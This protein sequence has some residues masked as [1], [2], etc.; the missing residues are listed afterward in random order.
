[1]I[2]VLGV[3]FVV[4]FLLVVFEVLFKNVVDGV[5]V[6]WEG[7]LVIWFVEF[8]KYYLDVLEGLFCILNMIFLFGMNEVKY[9]SL[10]VDLKKVI[11]NNSGLVIFVWV[12]EVGFD[13]VVV[14]YK[15]VVK[16]V[17][18]MLVNLSVV[19]YQC[20]VK[21]IDLVDDEWVKEIFVKGVDVKKLLEEVR[22]LV[23]QY[24]K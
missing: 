8:I 10:L 6:F 19:E 1:M 24:L 3:I 12:G 22:V 7:L 18:G 11:D 5:V 16:D 4:M 13:V 17:G 21:V 20:W 9:N 15:K 23:G 2:V 14:I